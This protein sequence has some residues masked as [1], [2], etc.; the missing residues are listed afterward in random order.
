MEKNPYSALKVYHHYDRI[1][2]LRN[3]KQP[4][5]VAVRLVL[6]DLCNQNCHFCTF[7]MENSFTNKNFSGFE[8]LR[9]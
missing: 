7:R 6:S 3:K 2:D 8:R 1:E 9:K 4:V 5:P